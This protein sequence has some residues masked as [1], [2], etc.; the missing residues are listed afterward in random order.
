VDGWRGAGLQGP[1]GEDPRHQVHQGLENSLSLTNIATSVQNLLVT[2]VSDPD[3][4]GK[5]NL[6]VVFSL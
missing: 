5:K 6:K 3:A 4:K 2:S 1:A